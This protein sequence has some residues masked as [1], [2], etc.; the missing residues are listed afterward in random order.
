MAAELSGYSDLLAVA[1]FVF[2]AF[3]VVWLEEILVPK[4]KNR[5]KKPK[6][7]RS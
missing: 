6:T 4:W 3:I 1:T 7:R 2:L 5:K